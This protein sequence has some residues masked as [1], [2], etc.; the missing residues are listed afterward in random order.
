[1]FTL[2]QSAKTSLS[3]CC[4]KCKGALDSSTDAGAIVEYACTRCATV[5][6]VICGIGDFRVYQDP[7]IDIA[8]DRAKGLKLAEKAQSMTCAQLV[9]YY[10]SITLEV[11]DDLAQYYLRHHLAG[12]V[13]G[14]GLLRR[15][16]EYD[17]PLPQP[18]NTLVDL[19]CGTGGFLSAAARETKAKLVGVD[20]AFRWLV[21]ARKR[22]QELG[23]ENVTL[24][25]ACADYMPFSDGTFDY[26]TAENLIEHVRDQSGLFAEIARTRKPGGQF[27]ARTVNRFAPGPEPHVGVWGVGYLPRR[28]MDPYVRAIK[29][30][31]YEHIHLQSCC[32][33]RASIQSSGQAD[34]HVE[35]AR[36]IP[37]DYQHHSI[38]K[39]KLF[40]M[41]AAATRIKPLRPALT[42]VGPYLDVI[43]KSV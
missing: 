35:C 19:G 16:R 2:E 17:M 13:R 30:I 23:I 33:L 15:L 22:L 36:L 3:Y 10:Y 14:S 43:T 24:I 37:D 8:A 20:I 21:V 1:M 5:Y 25:C 9:A 39:R 31:P 32:E 28:F 7:Y 34:L 18:Q 26:I 27:Y 11:P 41:Y 4:P 42:A 38:P 12:T 40:E 6:P 29:S